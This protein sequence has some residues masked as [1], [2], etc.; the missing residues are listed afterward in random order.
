MK[1]SQ[2]FV[3]FSEYMN[4]NV[5]FR[6]STLLFEI[7]KLNI[8]KNSPRISNGDYTVIQKAESCLVISFDIRL[9]ETGQLRL[10]FINKGQFLL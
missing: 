10:L 5:H 9:L 3:A 2:N 4:F 8:E 6:V 1:I 7:K